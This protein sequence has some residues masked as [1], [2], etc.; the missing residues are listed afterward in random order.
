[1]CNYHCPFAERK[2]CA[3][4]LLCRNL[5]QDGVNYNIRENAMTVICA[6]QKQCMMTGR[7][8]NSDEA[9]TCALKNP[10]T[11]GPE[12]APVPKKTKKKST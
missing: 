1:M 10:I 9:K 5:Y 3:G 12:P 6:H 7:M 11:A 8:E 4:F 2:P